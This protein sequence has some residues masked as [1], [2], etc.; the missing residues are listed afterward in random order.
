MIHRRSGWTGR[1]RLGGP[2]ARTCGRDSAHGLSAPGAQGN[3]ARTLLTAS[4]ISRPDVD[5]AGLQAVDA[6]RGGP[7]RP[8]V[9]MSPARGQLGQQPVPQLR[10]LLAGDLQSHDQACVAIRFGAGQ[11]LWVPRT[12][13]QPPTSA[14]T[15]I[16][17]PTSQSPSTA[18]T[19]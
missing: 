14:F 11:A 19:A 7:P 3:S 4:S 5:V 12:V 18:R 8:G 2:S 16:G 17:R 6:H 15:A 10:R 9:A 13:T 1:R